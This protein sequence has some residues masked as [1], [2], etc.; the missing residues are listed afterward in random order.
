MLLLF[1]HTFSPLWVF[2]RRPYTILVNK[3]HGSGASEN[4]IDVDFLSF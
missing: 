3:R 2:K 1:I 4:T